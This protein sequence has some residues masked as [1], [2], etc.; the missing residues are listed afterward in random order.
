[1]ARSPPVLNHDA[2][3]IALAGCC[4]ESS[5]FF[6]LLGIR[7]NTLVLNIGSNKARAMAGGTMN[8]RYI[9][10]SQR[11]TPLDFRDPSFYT[12]GRD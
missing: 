9:A 12:R 8:G 5:A 3:H 6:G 7:V 4:R 2:T 1:M 10:M 11:Q